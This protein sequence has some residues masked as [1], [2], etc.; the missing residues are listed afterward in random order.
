[1]YGDLSNRV[2]KTLKSETKAIEIY[3]IDE[4]FLD[5]NDIID[6]DRATKKLRVKFKNGLEY[7]FPLGFLLQKHCQK[8]QIKLRKRKTKAFVY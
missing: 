5:F 3:S 4:A 6:L 7:Q 2:M 1:M 8:L